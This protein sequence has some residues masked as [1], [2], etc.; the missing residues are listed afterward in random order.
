[1]S[2]FTVDDCGWNYYILKATNILTTTETCAKR[3]DPII[4]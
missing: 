3:F 4:L 2:E 1:M